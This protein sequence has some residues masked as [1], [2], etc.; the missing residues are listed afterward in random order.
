M[1]SSNQG[2]T[3][4]CC[5]VCGDEKIASL[6]AIN[7]VP[8][9]C[10]LLWPTRDAALQAPLGDVDLGF[11]ENCGHIFNLAFDPGL[12][13][14]TQDYENSLDF[15]PR[16]RQ[17]AQDLATR[18]V[19]GYDM[20]DKDIVEI[21]S[22]QGDFLKMLCD[23]G[24]NRGVGFD[25]SYVDDGT[26][27]QHQVRFVRDFYSEAYSNYPAD[28]ICSR[29]VLEHIHRP[30][31]FMSMVRRVV[32]QRHHV[33]VF[34]EVPNVLYTVRQLGIWDIIYEH[35]SYFSPPSLAAVFA[36]NGF[37]VLRTKEVFGGQFLTVEALPASGPPELPGVEAVA[38]LAQDVAVFA[39][40]YREKV[41]TWER[42][43][44]ECARQGRQAVVWGAG[45][46]GVTFLNTIESSAVVQ[47][48]VDINPRKKGMYVSG[49]GQEI[50]PPEFLP[51]IQPDVVIVMNPNYKDEIGG[52][53]EAIGVAAEVV[54]V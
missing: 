51:E 6:I 42:Y 5:T 30:A 19:E 35:A 54:L 41:E 29:H 28:F 34:F 46:K 13:E 44:E 53:L 40:K 4:R 24:H 8:V 17:Y 25:P 39:R 23:L 12:M 26:E 7:Q 31:E 11:C 43:L 14:Y 1:E 50:V 37:R 47:Y 20:H 10:N 18:L 2:P 22:G 33:V 52:Q 3:T 45:S 36:L 32:G 48:A 16:F 27:N 21:G 49:T 38:S 9:H 15:S